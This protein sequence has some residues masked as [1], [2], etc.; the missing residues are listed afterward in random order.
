MPRQLRC[1][2]VWSCSLV[3]VPTELVALTRLSKLTLS[4][5]KCVG[6]H[7]LPH[8]LRSLDLRSCDWFYQ[9]AGIAAAER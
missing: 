5:S 4:S 8:Q 2:E 7:N 9:E 3:E 6:L 1:L